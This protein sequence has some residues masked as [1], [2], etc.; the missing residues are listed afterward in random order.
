MQK[1]SDGES[2]PEAVM[3][4]F[5]DSVT[6][7]VYPD[8]I[9]CFSASSKT[10]EVR[11]SEMRVSNMDEGIS[12]VHKS[13][14]EELPRGLSAASYEFQRVSIAQAVG[15]TFPNPKGFGDPPVRLKISAVD[16]STSG[17]RIEIRNDRS[18]S[19]TVILSRDFETAT[20]ASQ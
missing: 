19:K 5:L 17:W 18:E 16:R 8:Q 10:L 6:C 1:A 7:S 2:N 14:T 20:S 13:M 15:P 4:E 3:K 12:N 9:A 11:T